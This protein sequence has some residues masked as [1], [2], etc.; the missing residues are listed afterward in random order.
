MRDYT[1][2]PL[3]LDEAKAGVA[4]LILKYPD[5]IN[6]MIGK[7]CVYDDGKG[8]HCIIGQLLTELGAPLPLENGMADRVCTG[9]YESNGPRTMTDEAAEWC[10]EV[11]R[12][13]DGYSAT[14]PGVSNPVKWGTI[15]LPA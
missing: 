9:Y 8:R 2:K 7:A 13:A 6:P 10:S 12:R 11:Q 5:N 4:A 1:I 15:K 3:T 14:N